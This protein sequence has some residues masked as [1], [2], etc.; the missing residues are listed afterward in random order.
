MNKFNNSVKQN[1]KTLKVIFTTI[2]FALALCLA[3]SGVLYLS[4]Q[5]ASAAPDSID[6]LQAKLDQT[7]NAYFEALQAKQ[8]CQEKVSEANARIE[9]C[10]VKIPEYQSDIMRIAKNEYITGPG[11]LFDIILG[12]STI[13]DLVSNVEAVTAINNKNAA[14]IK[15]CKNLRVEVEE[16]KVALDENLAQASEQANIASAA[17]NDAQETLQNAQEL[18][19]E[20]AARQQQQQQAQQRRN[21]SSGGGGAHMDANTGNAIAD[22]ALG[23]QG[24]PYVWGGVG[25]G[26]YDCSGLVSYA[27]SGAHTRIGTTTTF[28]GW[29]RLS[30]P[31]V[32]CVCTNSG[33]CGIY[34][35]GGSMCH[36]PTFGQTV[37]VTGVH[38]GMIYVTR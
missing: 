7:S 4:K 6:A 28:M 17:Y 32:G 35:G 38:G 29:P 34:V 16:Q 10:N 1:S 19:A 24:K 37:C 36:A 12:A 15:E 9:Y 31:E 21:A 25:P 13:E 8:E 27:V 11:T 23:E 3:T 20:A 5:E 30:S 33:H 22:R 18:A 2:I 26:G 14:L